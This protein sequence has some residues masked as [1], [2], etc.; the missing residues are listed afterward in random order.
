MPRYLAVSTMFPGRLTF[1]IRDQR[2]GLDIRDA[3]GR[4][5]RLTEP[6]LLRWMA[7][8]QREE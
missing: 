2:T 8:H 5:L 6:Q 3:T 4:A 7:R 1:Y